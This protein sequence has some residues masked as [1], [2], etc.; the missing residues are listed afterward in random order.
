VNAFSR[1]TERHPCDPR[2]VANENLPSS[3]RSRQVALW[4]PSPEYGREKTPA[5]FTLA[6][7][8]LCALIVAYFAGEYARVML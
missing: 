7:L 2:K 6:S 1:I 5:P 4:S 3:R 8:I